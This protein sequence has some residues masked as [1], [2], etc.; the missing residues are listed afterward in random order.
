MNQVKQIIRG[1]KILHVVCKK[2]NKEFTAEKNVPQSS[3]LDR[4]KSVTYIKEEKDDRDL[5][6][7]SP[8]I[9]SENVDSDEKEFREEV[10]LSTIDEKPGLGKEAPRMF[11][12]KPS[13]T[14][15]EFGSPRRNLDQTYNPAVSQ[16]GFF[17]GVSQDRPNFYKRPRREGRNMSSNH[18]S[19][20]AP[21]SGYMTQR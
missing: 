16:S 21:N 18:F 8:S 11:P 6:S 12:T 15:S 17:V 4:N 14:D 5:S 7:E 1:N 3:F 13:T 19:T 9:F 2:C 20:Q 10:R